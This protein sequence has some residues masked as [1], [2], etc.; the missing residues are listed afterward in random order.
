MWECQTT[1]LWTMMKTTHTDM[2][3]RYVISLS[4][5]FL[6]VTLIPPQLWTG[7]IKQ[8]CKCNKAWDNRAAGSSPPLQPAN[9]CRRGT[10]MRGGHQPPNVLQRRYVLPSL[11]FLTLILTISQYS[12]AHSP[13]VATTRPKPPAWDENTQ[14][15]THGHTGPP[16]WQPIAPV[17]ATRTTRSCPH[18]RGKGATKHGACKGTSP[19]TFF[20]FVFS[21]LFLSLRSN[22]HA[23][24]ATMTPAQGVT[25]RPSEAAEQVC[26]PTF[27]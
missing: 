24:M 3:C 10:Q 18:V 11:S 15:M 26:L 25:H 22:Y 21:H 12:H 16:R 14:T 2:Q 8:A 5:F 27:F 9:S 23:T 17:R 20:V 7:T 13:Q 4:F 1:N 6:L 19:P